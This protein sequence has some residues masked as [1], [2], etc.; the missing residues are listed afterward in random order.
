MMIVWNLLRDY[1]NSMYW[2]PNLKIYNTPR[3]ESTKS[4]IDFIFSI[5][6]T[7]D[8]KEYIWVELNLKENVEDRYYKVI[9][10]EFGEFLGNHGISMPRRMLSL[11]KN[12]IFL[13]INNCI[14]KILKNWHTEEWDTLNTFMNVCDKNNKQK[15]VKDIID[16][17]EEKFK[18]LII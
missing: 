1:F 6:E 18:N 9:C 7:K 16:E 17:T 14:D 11:D 13:M 5:D 3:Y 12:T 2:Y 10:T 4:K 8:L 15:G